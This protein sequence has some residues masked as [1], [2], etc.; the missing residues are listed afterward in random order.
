ML[1][2][3]QIN[4]EAVRRVALALG[5]LNRDVVFVGGAV[6]QLYID[7][8]AAEDVRPTKDVDFVIQ[9]ASLGKLED[10]RV[11]LHQKGFR[12]SAEDSVICRFRFH[13]IKVDV[14]STEPIG[15]AP[16][17]PWFE[18]GFN[19]MVKKKL[20]DVEVNLLPLPYFLA[21]K[22]SAFANRGGL[23]PRTSHDFED[24]VYILDNSSTVKEEIIKSPQDVQQYL[25]KSFSSILEN[26]S[27]Q[28][29]IIGNLFFDQQ[30]ERYNS[31]VQLL[32][33]TID[34]IK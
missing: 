17:N 30:M 27:L 10:L 15:W 21:T 16:A 14:M 6:V 31:I 22:F 32:I 25:K 5:E 19:K 24:I 3:A 23:D 29:T 4:I 26:R 13:D 9:I 11:L 1:T 18:G 2:H 33:D 12:Q 20:G 8:P 7:N 34:E 28:E